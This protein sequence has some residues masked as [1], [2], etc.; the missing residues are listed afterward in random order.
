MVKFLFWNIGKKP[1]EA[2]IT[3]LA[4]AHEI[5]V[6]IL[7]E[8]DISV[9]SMLK[10]LNRE[11]VLYEFAHNSQC[12]KL[13]IYTR[14]P[15][16]FIQPLFETGRWS[17]RRLS[18]PLRTDILVAAA[19]LPDKQS[20]SAESQAYESAELARSIKSV[21]EQV[22]HARTIVIGDFNMDPFEGGVYAA[23]G[24]NAAMTKEIARRESR[25][26]QGRQYDFFYNPMWGHFGD[27]TV[28][29][30]GTYYYHRAEHTTLFWHMFDQV[31]LRPELVDHFRDNELEI[32]TSD[33]NIS[34]LSAKGLPDAKIASDHLPL[35]FS[36]NL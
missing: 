1:L 5:D 3:N 17:I 30:P 21:E 25:T 35:L 27:Q 19:H 9:A 16:Q 12:P 4:L 24:L 10:M 2:I 18:L 33:G 28:G 14:F 29:P 36:L 6:L 20:H 23:A 22:G 13:A 26:V 7:A 11:S 8:C 32:L 15:N 31:L 34:F